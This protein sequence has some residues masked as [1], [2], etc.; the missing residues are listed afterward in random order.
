MDY[1]NLNTYK[2]QVKYIK[3]IYEMKANEI[4]HQNEFKRQEKFNKV[5]EGVLMLKMFLTLIVI[6]LF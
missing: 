4:E 3:K 2:M 6:Y 5:Y 1:T